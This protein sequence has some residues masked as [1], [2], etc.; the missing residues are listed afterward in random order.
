MEQKTQTVSPFSNQSRNQYVIEHITDAL[1]ELLKKKPLDE[2]SISELCD[3][4]MVGRTSFYRNFESKEDVIG[5]EIS[6]ILAS[7]YRD[8]EN[9][10]AAS[11]SQ[12]FGSL[13][14]VIEK[15]K[16]FFLLL[17]KRNL[18]YLLL[19]ASKSLFNL[20]KETSN[21][22]AY[23]K[24]YVVYSTYGLLS[25]WITRGMTESAETMIKLLSHEDSDF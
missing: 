12:I 9:N 20:Q 24:A 15:N 23:A 2:I 10:E 19:E 25:E 1:I 18:L 22:A 21:I 4:A 6:V 14:A 7:W 11:L 16:D 5:K 13:F 8:F 17:E 3:T